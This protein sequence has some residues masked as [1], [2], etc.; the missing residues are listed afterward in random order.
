MEKIV[1]FFKKFGTWVI[2]AVNIAVISLIIASDPDFREGFRALESLSLP[3]VALCFFVLFAFLPVAKERSLYVFLRMFRCSVSA[4]R[5]KRAVIV[6]RYY[7]AITPTNI[8][9]QPP[10]MVQCSSPMA[11]RRPAASLRFMSVRFIASIN[12]AHVLFLAAMFR[13]DAPALTITSAPCFFTP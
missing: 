6:E 4:D 1:A 3:Y 7:S 9:G 11:C 12:D 2:L 8:G 13:A 10:L 5:S